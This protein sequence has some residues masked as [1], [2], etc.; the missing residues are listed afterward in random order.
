MNHI[1]V[2]IHK[3]SG[4]VLQSSD[5]HFLLLNAVFK[6]NHYRQNNVSQFKAGLVH[7]QLT[8]VD[9]G[10]IQH[11]F[12]QAG[13][14]LYLVGDNFQ[15]IILFIGRDRAVQ[16]PVDKAGDGSHGGFQ[17]VGNISDEAPPGSLRGGQRRRHVVERHR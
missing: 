6:G 13:K 15:I 3:N 5:F 9:S 10:K 8:V 11:G 2:A 4:G 16:N 7:P 14:P 17:L 1:R 12:Y